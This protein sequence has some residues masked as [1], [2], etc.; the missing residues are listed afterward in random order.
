[1]ITRLLISISALLCIGAH[2][3]TDDCE[4]RLAGDLYYGAFS[5]GLRSGALTDEDLA[6]AAASDKPL[7]PIAHQATVSRNTSL[8]RALS[9]LINHSQVQT[10][11]PAI[12][13][14]LQVLVR[15]RRREGEVAFEAKR[16]TRWLLAPTLL[17][18]FEVSPQHSAV[19]TLSD[20]TAVLAYFESG[21]VTVR[22]AD[23]RAQ[24]YSHK[25]DFVGSDVADLYRFCWNRDQQ[26]R[27]WLFVT[28]ANKGVTHIYKIQIETQRIVELK[29]PFGNREISFFSIRSAGPERVLA[30]VYGGKRGG[31][32]DLS[33]EKVLDLDGDEEG[34]AQVA[35][36]P[37][38]DHVFP[39]A[40][41][42]GYATAES[43]PSGRVLQLEDNEV[44][45]T[46][47]VTG[48]DGAPRSLKYSAGIRIKFA[49]F[50]E[51]PDGRIFLAV[52]AE[53]RSNPHAFVYDLSENSPDPIYEFEFTWGV[54]DDFH[55][56][57]NPRGDIFLCAFQNNSG[58][59]LV[60]LEPLART[61]VMRVKV[62]AGAYVWVDSPNQTYFWTTRS[63]RV[64]VYSVF[65]K[66]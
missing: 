53:T 5:T 58:I 54:M 61:L 42:L 18:S 34:A 47:T 19:G 66:E 44:R 9:V 65:A 38:G 20:G 24:V 17:N 27:S 39:K 62:D 16:E 15:E 21:K 46:F 31:V 4:S 8:R 59:E 12:K 6:L 37:N 57:Q 33:V 13:E 35:T 23:N 14:K 25:F 63:D 2:A 43:T 55:F 36:Q 29:H 26:G 60:V 56:F 51:A 30:E 7:N 11:W 41:L 32:Y 3:A 45:R 64:S 49:K 10:S 28:Y 22:R 50:Y 48:L 40:L 52:M 1:M